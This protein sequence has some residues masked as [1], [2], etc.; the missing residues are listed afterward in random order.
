MRHTRSY[1]DGI[2]MAGFVW[3]IEP[4]ATVHDHSVTLCRAVVWSLIYLLV[5]LSYC[6]L[7]VIAQE[8]PTYVSEYKIL[9]LTTVP[10]LDIAGRAVFCL[11]CRYRHKFIIEFEEEP[12]EIVCREIVEYETT[13]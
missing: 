4:L 10:S 12:P 2:Y 11:Y 13:V 5:D 3:L 9:I 6:V 7:W 8:Y 1:N